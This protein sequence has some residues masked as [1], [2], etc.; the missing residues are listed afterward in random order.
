MTLML[1]AFAV[2][3]GS[4]RDGM[5]WVGRADDPRNCVRAVDE[6]QA[7][8]F[9]ALVRDGEPAHWAPAPHGVMPPGLLLSLTVPLPWRPDGAADP[10]LCAQVPLPG[11]TLINV[12]TT[13]AHAAPIPLGARL[14]VREEVVAVSPA[15]RTRLG[16][17]HFL[18]T[19]S[20]FLDG[21]GAEVARH[22]NVMLRYSADA[23]RASVP[24]PTDEPTGEHAIAIDVTLEQCVLNVASTHD[25]FPGH[26]DFAYATGQGVAGPFLNTMFFQG[27]V[28]RAALELLGPGHRVARRE[29]RMRAPA[30]VGDTVR[31]AAR[32]L[33]P[34]QVAVAVGTG[35]GRC[36]DAVVVCAP[37]RADE[38]TGR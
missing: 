11:D 6:A 36:A 5:A 17:G 37:V 29:L 33:G 31:A 26:Y 10:P 19:R 20:V 32:R 16:T 3:S 30:C 18:T 4:E 35:A 28:D 34:R 21:E 9:C 15:K 24:A 14:R 12:A 7:R 23:P 1:R 38:S 2:A 25:L 8:L 27:L 22:D 13:T